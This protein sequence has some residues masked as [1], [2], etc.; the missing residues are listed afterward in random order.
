MYHTMDPEVLYL[1]IFIVSVYW[2]PLVKLFCWNLLPFTILTVAILYTG[3]SVV[4]SIYSAYRTKQYLGVVKNYSPQ[5]L[6]WII[7]WCHDK[8]MFSALLALCEENPPLSCGFPLQRPMISSD[9]ELSFMLTW[10]CWTTSW[11]AGDLRNQGTFL[12]ISHGIVTY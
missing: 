2:M 10:T 9:V 4:F 1:T 11:V 8:D 5:Q 12:S 6:M 3:N 7:W